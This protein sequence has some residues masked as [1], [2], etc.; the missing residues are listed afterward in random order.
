MNKKIKNQRIKLL[1]DVRV[2]NN[3]I[4]MKKIKKNNHMIN[5]MTLIYQDLNNKKIKKIKIQDKIKIKIKINK[6]IKI[7]HN[8]IKLNKTYNN[9]KDNKNKDNNNF[10]MIVKINNYP[11]LI[12]NYDKQRKYVLNQYKK[13]I[14]N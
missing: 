9:Y 12:L 7:I 6:K 13:Y 8:K 10:K 5:Q 14:F 2:F 3:K 4:K 1:R 11:S